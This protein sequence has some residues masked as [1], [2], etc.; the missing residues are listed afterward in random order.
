VGVVPAFGPQ[1]RHLDRE[2]AAGALQTAGAPPESARAVHQI[3]QATQQE[4]ER[5]RGMQNLNEE[6][7]E[8]LIAAAEAERDRTLK[9]FLGE[10]AF[11]KFTEQRQAQ[12]LDSAVTVNMLFDA[13][14]RMQ[15]GREWLIR[16]PAD[17]SFRQTQPDIRS[18]NGNLE[19]RIFLDYSGSLPEKKKSP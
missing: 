4:I 1:A 7:R 12:A 11:G 17:A 19:R 15:A 16:S 10:D 3:N 5:V 8:N 6:Q 13:K 18:L 2:G 14:G 9:G